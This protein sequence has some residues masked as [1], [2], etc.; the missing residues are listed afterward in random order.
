MR[1]SDFVHLHNHSKYSLL[2]GACRIDRMVQR[3]LE[4]RMPALAIT[5][6]GNMFGAIEF[7]SEAREHGIKPIIG[8]EAYVT[9]GSHKD[10]PAGKGMESYYH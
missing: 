8:M 4:F 6:H 1:H 7:Y 3:A 5:D 2:D 9:S 10:R